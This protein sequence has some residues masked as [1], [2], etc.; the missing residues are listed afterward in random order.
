M[1]RRRYL[2]TDKPGCII[3]KYK[4]NGTNSVRLFF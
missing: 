2:D 1:A 4:G 3:A